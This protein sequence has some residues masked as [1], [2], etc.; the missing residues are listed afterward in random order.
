MRLLAARLWFWAA[1]VRPLKHILPVVALVRVVHPRPAVPHRASGLAERLDALFRSPGRFPRRPPS[2]CLERALGA[3]RLL[4]RAGATPE[5]VI[6]MRRGPGDAIEGHTWVVVDGR[7]LGE[8]EG[9]LAGFARILA[10]DAQG[11][12]TT[13]PARLP[14]GMRV[15]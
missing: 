8:E 7:P 11:R 14:R 4:C 5:L 6:G 13:G 2:N 9:A 12:Q 1:V 10:F 15:A 3:Y